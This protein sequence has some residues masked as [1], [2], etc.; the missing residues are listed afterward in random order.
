MTDLEKLKALLTEFGVGFGVIC[1]NQRR[2]VTC[3]E[4][5]DKVEGYPNFYTSFVFDVRGKFMH[6]GAYE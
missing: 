4:S 2:V 3:S 5:A 6:M 1:E